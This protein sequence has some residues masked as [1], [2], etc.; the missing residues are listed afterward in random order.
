VLLS[1]GETRAAGLESTTLLQFLE[2]LVAR[3]RQHHEPKFFFTTSSN[4]MCPSS[5]IPRWSR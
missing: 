4:A 5:R 3:W 1:A 2:Q